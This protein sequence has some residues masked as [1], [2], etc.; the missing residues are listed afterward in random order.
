M[1]STNDWIVDIG[2]LDHMTGSLHGLSNYKRCDKIVTVTMAD[3]TISYAKGE[4][5]VYIDGLHLKSILYVPKLKCNRLSIS[6]ITEMNYKVTFFPNS[7]CFS[8]PNFG[9]DD[10]QC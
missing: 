4:R 3:G 6:K 2:A 7:L 8:R 9:K 10:Q 5:S 1:L